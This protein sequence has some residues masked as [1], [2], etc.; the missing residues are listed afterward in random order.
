LAG[1][2]HC[3][4]AALVGAAVGF[5]SLTLGTGAG[6]SPM[7]AAESEV[8][9]IFVVPA[10]GG[11]A[12]RVTDNDAYGDEVYA[13]DPSWSPDGK[14][15]LFSEVRCDG[16]TPEI[17]VVRVGPH[18]GNKWLR[19]PI[20]YGL[21]PRWAPNGKFVAYVAP[22]G[23]I[24][25]MSPDGSHRRLLAKG[26]FSQDGPSWSPD[27]R[28]LVFGQQQTAT[29]WRLYAVHVDGSH[30]RP[31]TSGDVPAVDPAWS[32]DGR[33]IA[34]AQ[35]RGRWHIYTLSLR[36]GERKRVSGRRTSDSFPTW[37]PDG[38][39]LAVV[40]QLRSSTAIFTMRSDGRE[41]RRVSPR[42]LVS[43][44]PAWSP[45][46]QQIAFAGNTG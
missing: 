42:S 5:A 7:R 2:R 41:V 39:R 23:G 25:V 10:Q 46:G 17:H 11:R 29:R 19:R 45:G 6:A 24:Y 4:P 12:V 18:H 8:T 28:Q 38:R 21:F 37:S 1:F 16:C 34:F 44:Q 36:G 9:D 43:L 31:L 13:Y 14:R 22:R 32:P 20:G 27:S 30:L 15:I 35:Q 33:K 26:G 3:L 40:R